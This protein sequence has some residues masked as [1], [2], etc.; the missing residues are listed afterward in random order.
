MNLC[1]IFGRVS[2]TIVI[3]EYNP[4]IPWRLYNMTALLTFT[5]WHYQSFTVSQ[6]KTCF[7]QATVFDIICKITLALCDTNFYR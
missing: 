6:T 1:Q 4:D 2:R 7:L 3:W 5:R